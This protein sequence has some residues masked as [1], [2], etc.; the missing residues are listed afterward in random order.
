MAQAV[1]GSNKIDVRGVWEGHDFQSCRKNSK[2]NAALAAEV[3][4]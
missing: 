4:S 3:C 2:I 1:T